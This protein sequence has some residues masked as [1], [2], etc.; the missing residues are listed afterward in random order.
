MDE[1]LKSKCCCVIDFGTWPELAIR[2]SREFGRVLYFSAWIQA[3]PKR[4]DYQVGIG[5]DG[6]ERISDW[7]SHFDEIDLFVFPHLY[8]APLQ[9][10]LRS[11]GKLVWGNGGAEEAELDRF[12]FKKWMEQV[13]LP[14]VPTAQ[15]IGMKALRDHLKK[16][17]D[18]YIKTSRFRGDQETW[19][20]VDYETS[21]S[22][23]DKREYSLGPI[24]DQ[25]EFLVEDSVKGIEVGF[26]G[27]TINGQYPEVAS[28]GYEIKDVG[29]VGVI[30]PYSEFPPEMTAINEKMSMIFQTNKSRGWY[31]NEVRITEDGRFYLTDPTIRCFSSDTEILTENGWKL[32][33]NLIRGEKVATLN[34]ETRQIEYQSP[35]AYIGYPYAGEMVSIKSD[36]RSLDQL[37]TPNHNVW[38]LTRKDTGHAERLTSCRADQMS[39][40]MRIPRTGTWVGEEQPFFQLPAYSNEWDS[41][42]NGKIHK[43]KYCPPIDIEMDLWLKFLGFYLSEGSCHG[44]GWSVQVT[45]T[46]HLEEFRFVIAQLPFPWGEDKG[47]LALHSVQ[48][49]QY[50]RQFGLCDKKFVPDFVKRLSPRQINI[51]LDAYT[52]GDGYVKGGIQRIISTTSK[53]MADDLQ[54]LFFKVGSLA[55]IRRDRVKGTPMSVRGGK[56]YIRNHDGY[57]VKERSRRSVFYLDTCDKRYNYVKRVPYE[58]MVF[59]VTVPNGIVYVRRNGKPGWSGNCPYPPGEA[60]MEVYENLGEILYYGAQGQMVVPRPL[61]KYF[62]IARIEA[63]TSEDDWNTLFFPPEL[64]QWIKLH[65]LTI[66]NGRSYTVP[67]RIEEW[68]RIGSVIGFGDTVDD[69]IGTV[70]ERAEQLKGFKLSTTEDKLDEAKDA[71]QAG[72]EAG[73]EF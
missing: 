12:A 37:V 61:T 15:I 56:I 35:T 21:E 23:L 47:G 63:P 28:L 16:V 60:L 2:L 34:P 17:E 10:L 8:N 29:F 62:A 67:H 40:K 30:K 52:M 6:V 51:F 46:K 72:E 26:D 13:G 24:K 44:G 45:Q 25:V 7:E 22:F 69:A 19:H 59:D 65:D 9:N 38:Y 57:V 32:F 33:P 3:F 42:M 11:M 71:I 31:S 41:G 54:E 5:L 39:G 73:I 4:N 20:H 14:V 43:R 53:R 1:S 18:K 48:L 49:H 64:R 58:G 50:L 70:R 68:T 36:G 27:W 55:N 66:I